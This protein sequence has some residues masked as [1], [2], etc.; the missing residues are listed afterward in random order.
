MGDVFFEEVKCRGELS[1][2]S[3][4][5]GRMGYLEDGK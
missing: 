3:T 1:R 2:F 4:E 5:N